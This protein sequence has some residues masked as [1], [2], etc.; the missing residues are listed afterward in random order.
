MLALEILKTRPDL[1]IIL[2]TGYS[3][4]ISEQNAKDIGIKMFCTKPL[5]LKDLA[6]NIR[7]VLDK[8]VVS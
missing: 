1:P 2:C 8:D 7:K 6:Y 5:G 4:K 3:R